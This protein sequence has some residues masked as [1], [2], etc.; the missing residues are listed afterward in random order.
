METRKAGVAARFGV[1]ARAHGAAL[2]HGNP[3]R[4]VKVI[5]VVGPDGARSTV[6]FLA[7]IL[8]KAG[9]RVGVITRQY[10]EIAD[11]HV[12][13]SDKAEVS[14]DAHRLQA[15]LSQM[16]RARC[17][18]AIIEV[19]P[20]LP[21]HQFVG[22]HAAMVVVRCCGDN[23]IDQMTVAA[24]LAMLGNVLARKPERI[25]YNRDD[26]CGAE[27]AHLT[28]QEGVISFGTHHKAE[29]KITEVRLHPKGSA[30]TL[31]IDH[32]T[33]MSLVTVAAGKQAIYSAAAAAAAAYVLHVPLTAIEDGIA[34]QRVLPGQLEYLPLQRAYQ[35]VLDSSVTPGGVAEVLD[36]L[37]HFAKNRL[38][39]VLSASLDVAS[40]WRPLLGEIAHAHADRIIVTDGEYAP[41]QSATQVRQN[42]LQGVLD[43]GGEAKTEEIPDRAVAIEKAVSIARRGDIIAICGVTLRPYRQ[44]GTQ[45]VPWSEYKV[46]E[47]LFG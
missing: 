43:S 20:E 14:S 13:G 10:V 39:V 33:Q 34:A 6:A 8:R 42:I 29:G 22:V 1:K 32:Q 28:G 47:E 31:V 44:L 17:S 24:R 12:E 15:L 19:P 37:Q 36:T 7:T 27:L 9:E 46:F 35:I 25:V 40:S 21:T 16:K 4:K 2:R 41:D 30:L 18:Y 11:E 23:Y 26:P 45:R 3:S 5:L 38:I